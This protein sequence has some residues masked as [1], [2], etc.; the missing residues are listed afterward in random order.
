MNSRDKDG[1]T[2]LHYASAYGRLDIVQ[3]LVDHGADVN[4]TQ[5]HLWT[6][7]HLASSYGY[8]GIARL[9]LD[10]GANVDA[11]NEDGLTACQVAGKEE[12]IQL[13]SDYGVRVE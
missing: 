13:F 2:P 11:R 3:L 12:V 1:E 8:L 6:T 5:Q 10:R 9:L 7:L 4:A